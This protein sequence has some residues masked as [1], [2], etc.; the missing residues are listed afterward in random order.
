[1]I[2]KE[3]REFAEKYLLEEGDH[4]SERGKRTYLYGEI[5]NALIN[6]NYRYNK[7]MKEK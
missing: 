3:A 2:S 7:S 6:A 4:F 5:Q 1:M